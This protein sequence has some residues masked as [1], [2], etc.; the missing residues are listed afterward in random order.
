MPKL[1]PQLI[2]FIKAIGILMI[3]TLLTFL[4]DA[5]HLN[6]IVSPAVAGLI[7]AIASWLETDIKQN[8]GNALFGAAKVSST[9]S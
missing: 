5:S 3:F 1:S 7:A 6:G 2:S 4:G 8:T 9:P